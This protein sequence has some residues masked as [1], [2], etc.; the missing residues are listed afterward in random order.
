M[1]EEAEAAK[2]AFE[3]VAE[4]EDRAVTKL[5]RMKAAISELPTDMKEFNKL[6]Q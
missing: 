4:G 3:L 6:V 1:Q 2:R 5:N